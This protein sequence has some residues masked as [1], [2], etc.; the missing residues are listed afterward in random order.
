MSDEKTRTAQVTSPISRPRSL[1]TLVLDQIRDLII[2]DKLQLGDQLSENALSEQLGVSRT[3][4]REAF[5]HLAAERLVEVKPQR[6]TFVFQYD[7]T[8]LREISELREVL[9]TGAMRVAIKHDRRRL[10]DGLA[11]QVEAAEAAIHLG[12]AAY[13]SHDTAFHETLV[14]A[15][16]NRELIDAYQRISGRIRAIRYR[17]TTTQDQIAQS[18]Y[19]HRGILE[20]MRAGDDADAIAHLTSHVYNSYRFMFGTSNQT[21]DAPVPGAA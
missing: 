17:L 21:Q 15:S 3:P 4:V 16:D 20:S 19:H 5:L 11:N 14:R 1:T 13:Q 8:E 12:P 6:G 2:T 10:V 7:L 18:Q 9:E